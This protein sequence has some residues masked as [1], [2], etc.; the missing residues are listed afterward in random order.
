MN[1]SV[2]LISNFYFIFTENRIPNYKLINSLADKLIY[3]QSPVTLSSYE[4]TLPQGGAV[5]PLVVS[6]N[7]FSSVML[8][9]CSFDLFLEEQKTKQSVLQMCHRSKHRNHDCPNTCSLA[10]VQYINYVFRFCTEMTFNLPIELNVF[11]L[12]CNVPYM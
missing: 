2:F 9:V 12:Y 8:G 4:D 6:F 7:S 10:T 1:Y 11:R 5:I 3:S